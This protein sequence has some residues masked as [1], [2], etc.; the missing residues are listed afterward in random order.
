MRDL[1][2]VPLFGLAIAACGPDPVTPGPGPDPAELILGTGHEDGSPGFVTT[3]E[4]QDLVLQPGAQGGFH[5]FLNI[6]MNDEAASLVSMTPMIERH[7]RRVVDGDLVSRSEHRG[8]FVASPEAGF[9]E[10]ERSIP[11]FLCP[12][13]VGISVADELLELQVEAYDDE[14]GERM[15]GHLRFVPRCPE[16]DQK[17]FCE[18]ICF[19]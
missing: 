10:T 4:G 18:R 17:T 1:V 19:G 2:F 15:N 13:P 6:R 5:V 7:A 14:T 9:N 11:V 3:E 12:T 16:G 8:K